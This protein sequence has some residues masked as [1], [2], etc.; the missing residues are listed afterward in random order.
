M[1]AFVRKDEENPIE[2][3]IC[4]PLS[5]TLTESSWLSP[6]AAKYALERLWA[7]V[8][9][10]AGY[11]GDP[12]ISFSACDA[13]DPH[14]L[15]HLEHGRLPHFSLAE[16]LPRSASAPIDSKVP[17]ALFHVGSEDTTP[18]LQSK[19]DTNSIRFNVDLVA[20]TFFMLSRWE[21]TVIA[22]RDRHGRFPA[23]ASLAY[24]HGFLDHPIIDE[25]AL[26]IRQWLKRL[27]PGWEAHLPKFRVQ[28]SHDI[29][30]PLAYTYPANL[31]RTLGHNLITE[32]RP[33]NGIKEFMSHFP[34]T[35]D[36]HRDPYYLNLLHLMD[37]SEHHG[38][39]SVFYAMTERASRMDFYHNNPGINPYRLMIKEIVD[40]GH[41][42]GIHPSYNT[43]LNPQMLY[44]E[45]A[46][47]DRTLQS[48]S[49]RSRQHYLRFQSPETW[50][51]L[52]EAGLTYDS[53]LSFADHAGFRCGTCHPFPTYDI[54]ADR[55][56]KL[57]E[58]PLI[59][60]D[61]TLKQYMGLTPHDGKEYIVSLAQR[62]RAVRGVFSLLWHNSALSGEWSEWRSTYQEIVG[63]LSRMVRETPS[64]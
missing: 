9:G 39:T 52:E 43:F 34:A 38:L 10:T 4:G 8:S 47:L 32:R 26:I 23:H 64:S 29:D 55:T 35:W 31:I 58:E 5:Y 37:L 20:T 3:I 7:I 61:G 28:L 1:V 6:S 13:K 17:P 62:C 57:V 30:H 19:D 45:K 33:L 42:V 11:S 40:R 12:I 15:L 22:E 51:H 27:K 60:M 50:Q 25:W 18:V 44:Q 46:R 48:D 36:W 53:T 54:R 63:Q 56:M 49:K 16:I 2:R 14:D 24:K 59:V 41:E 21:E